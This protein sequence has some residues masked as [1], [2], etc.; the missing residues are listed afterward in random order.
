MQKNANETYGDFAYKMSIYFKFWLLSVEAFDDVTV[1]REHIQM[2]QFMLMIPEVIKIWLRE[3]KLTTL[4]EAAK[5]S[6][7]HAA[8]HKSQTVNSANVGQVQTNLAVGN[9]YASNNYRSLSVINSR[10]GDSGNARGSGDK[11][12]LQC[13]RCGKPN[14]MAKNC[15]SAN[16]LSTNGD[17]NQGNYKLK[18]NNDFYK[19]NYLALLD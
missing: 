13:Y 4:A 10:G 7:E 11:P 14:H 17:N 3:R 5:F 6:D 16:P 8:V 1:M 15:R 19:G 12:K 2:E 9:N 18:P